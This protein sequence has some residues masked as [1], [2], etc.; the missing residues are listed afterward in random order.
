VRLADLLIDPYEHVYGAEGPGR[1]DSPTVPP[2]KKIRF[3]CIHGGKELI[4]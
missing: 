3:R 2:P 4:V 1:P